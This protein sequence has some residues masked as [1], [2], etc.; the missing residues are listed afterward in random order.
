MAIKLEISK[1]YDILE[2][3][4]RKIGF[5]VVWISRIMTCVSLVS[6]AIKVNGQPGSLIKPSRGIYQGDPIF[7]YLYLI[8]AEG[9]ST[10]LNKSEKDL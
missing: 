4:M 2:V 8:C 1:A 5:D 6:Y 9:L 3:M 10:Q 7:P